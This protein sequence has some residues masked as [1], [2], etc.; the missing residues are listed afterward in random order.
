MAHNTK[1]GGTTYEIVGGRAMVDD[2]NH[3]I[4]QGNPKIG[5]TTY[6]I[7]LTQTWKR[8]N[9][10]YSHSLVST[11]QYLA[12]DEW[13]DTI[14]TM[15]SEGDSPTIEN[16]KFKFI[17]K[18][19]WNRL[20]E[21]P[22]I[23]PIKMAYSQVVDKYYQIKSFST[24]DGKYIKPY[25]DRYYIL[26]KNRGSTYTTITAPKGTY[27]TDGIQGDYWYVLQE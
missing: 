26:G 19:T 23:L 11:G 7:P 18:Q 4:E 5:G 1:I 22:N 6:T 27:P 8:F 2:A 17:I 13:T 24:S 3:L 10:S 25:S 12:E 20:V 16:G 9:I 21:S 14:W 15:T